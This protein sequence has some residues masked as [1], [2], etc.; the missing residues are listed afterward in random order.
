MKLGIEKN[1]SLVVDTTAIQLELKKLVKNALYEPKK[2]TFEKAKKLIRNFSG[3]INNLEIRN[4]FEVTLAKSF[5]SWYEI[6]ASRLNAL[7]T[8]LYLMGVILEG[9]EL[10]VPLSELPPFKKPLY[11]GVPKNIDPKK[12]AKDVRAELSKM[13]DELAKGEVKTKKGSLRNRA[14]VHT[15][16]E[17]QQNELDGLRARGVEYVWASSHADA[18]VRCTPFQGKMYS[19]IGTSGVLDGN[20]YMP[21]EDAMR[22]T[23]GDGNGLLGYNCRH[24]LTEYKK[25]SLP[26]DDYTSMELQKE[27]AIDEEQ[28]RQERHIRKLKEK[29]FLLK[30]V[31]NKK[32]KELF[33]RARE[34]TRE[35]E[36]FSRDNDRAFYPY[37]TQVMRSEIKRLRP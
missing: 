20:F 32:S 24:R 2:T 18:S 27:R 9:K 23:K 5:K 3:K 29:A 12:Y 17:A 35:Y 30:G 7:G 37:R 14:E 19:L 15:R 22:G 33:T 6:F 28:R 13:V 26:P 1:Y 25:G 8:P 21:I 36:Q 31:D 11:K 10:K 4:E 34:K 16:Y